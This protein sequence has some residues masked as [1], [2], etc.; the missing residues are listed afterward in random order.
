MI[1]LCTSGMLETFWSFFFVC[2]IHAR[3]DKFTGQC[4]ML[5]NMLFSRLRVGVVAFSLLR[6]IKYIVFSDHFAGLSHVPY[7]V[8][9]PGVQRGYFSSARVPLVRHNWRSPS[10]AVEECS[11]G[12]CIHLACLFRRLLFFFWAGLIGIV[13]KWLIT[14]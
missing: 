13:L 2:L 11:I 3:F 8:S 7:T 10:T 4:S 1:A 5:Y 14:H 9:T 12:F 6:F